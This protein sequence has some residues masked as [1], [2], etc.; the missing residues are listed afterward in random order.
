MGF[1]QQYISRFT[2][3]FFDVYSK[4]TCELVAF[5]KWICQPKLS[6]LVFGRH[7]QCLQEDESL[8]N[9]LI[10]PVFRRWSNWAKMF[11]L[12]GAGGTVTIFA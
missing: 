2:K 11:Q 6:L 7:A 1:A 5:K 3:E 9:V 12:G 8:G 4:N 10:S